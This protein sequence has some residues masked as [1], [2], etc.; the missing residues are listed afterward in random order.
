M[1]I[2]PQIVLRNAPDAETLRPRVEALVRRLERFAK[3]MTSCRVRIER[4]HLR[5]HEGNR[6]RVQIEVTLPGKDIVVRRDPPAHRPHEDVRVALRE[7]FDAVRR[8]IEDLVRVRR[9]DVKRHR[10]ALHGRIARLAS[11]EGFGFLRTPDGREVY[12]NA[13]SV[14]GESFEGLRVGDTVA[15]AEEGGD[16]GE[17]AVWVR[18]SREHTRWVD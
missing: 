15:F 11:G 3:R 2:P 4:P 7:S 17:Q 13:R 12:F 10:R 9:G 8:R 6:Y 14:V 16:E 18:R 5:H 1:Q